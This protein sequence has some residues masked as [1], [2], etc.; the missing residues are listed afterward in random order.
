MGEFKGESAGPARL[1]RFFFAPSPL[2]LAVTA[3][4]R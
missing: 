2:A 1:R 3:G 4:Y